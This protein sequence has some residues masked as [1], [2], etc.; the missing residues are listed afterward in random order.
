MSKSFIKSTKAKVLIL[1]IL[2]LTMTTMLFG[3]YVVSAETN[4]DTAQDLTP[5]PRNE[6]STSNFFFG[7]IVFEVNATAANYIWP[8][9][10]SF[11]YSIG[12]RDGSVSSFSYY[13]EAVFYDID[14]IEKSRGREPEKGYLTANKSVE[15]HIDCENGWPWAADYVVYSIVVS[16]NG[17]SQTINNALYFYG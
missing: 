4:E 13:V 8:F 11:V 1:S 9:A 15:G 6:S 14:G 2:V 12:P 17:E 7:D 3:G 5:Q 16:Y 10:D